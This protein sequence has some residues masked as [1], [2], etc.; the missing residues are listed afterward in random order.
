MGNIRSNKELRV[1]QAAMDAAMRI[2]ELTRV[3]ESP[4]LRV[5]ASLNRSASRSLTNLLN[6]DGTWF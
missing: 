6:V 5:P 2:F 3:T 1:Y 4:R